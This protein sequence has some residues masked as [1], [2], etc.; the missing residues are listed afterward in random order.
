VNIGLIGATSQLG[1]ELLKIL[2][3]KILSISSN[4][5]DFCYPDKILD[6]L[7]EYRESLD[8]LINCAAFN[9]VDEAENNFNADL[10]NSES[11]KELAQFCSISNILLIHFS[12][13]NVFDGNKGD[14]VET[15]IT[16]PINKYGITKLLGERYIQKYASNYLIIR[17]SWLYSKEGENSF[18]RKILHQINSNIPKIYGVTDICGSPTSASSLAQGMKIVLEHRSIFQLKE[19]FHFSNEGTATKYELIK[20]IFKITNNNE[21]NIIKVNN[22]FFDL[23]APR[24]R[25]TNLISTKFSSFFNFKIPNWKD[26]LLLCLKN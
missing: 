17:T 8:V 5:L 9:S 3:Y 23:S 15:D 24:P 19:I 1:R 18:V 12:T 10:I 22:D 4:E 20:E 14:Y 13:D 6:T 16:N 26:E 7:W 2:P 11:V 21:K 25:K